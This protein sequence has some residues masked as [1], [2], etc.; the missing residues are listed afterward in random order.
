MTISTDG[1]SSGPR[2]KTRCRTRTFLLLPV[3]LLL[4][5]LLFACQR[6]EKLRADAGDDFSVPVGERPTFDG[7]SSTGD[8]ANYKWRIISCPENKQE[9]VGKVIRE[10]Q[11]NCSLT[12]EVEMVVEEV[13]VWEIELQVRD[14]DGNSSTD[15]VRVEVTR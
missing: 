5:G 6:E 2:G 1:T 7:C 8:I 12:L 11:P 3:L 14:T 9:D 15:T 10:V 4:L 13:G